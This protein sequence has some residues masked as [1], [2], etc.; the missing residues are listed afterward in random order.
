MASQDSEVV[1]KLGPTLVCKGWQRLLRETVSRLEVLEPMEG[2]RR[3]I[4][5][6]DARKPH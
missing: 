4:Q 1:Y 2:P 6:P 3:A 5:G